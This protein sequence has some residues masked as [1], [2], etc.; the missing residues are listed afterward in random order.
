[1]VPRGLAVGLELCFVCVYHV[2]NVYKLKSGCTVLLKW[3]D[4][5]TAAT[6]QRLGLP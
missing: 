5:A 4:V 6:A 3:G 2:F 1:M